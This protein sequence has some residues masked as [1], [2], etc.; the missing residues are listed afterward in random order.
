MT[1]YSARKPSSSKLS[2]LPQKPGMESAY[3]APRAT[4]TSIAAAAIS[5][6]AQEAMTTQSRSALFLR[7]TR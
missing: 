5:V 7:P 1:A 6:T 4:P 3:T 2:P